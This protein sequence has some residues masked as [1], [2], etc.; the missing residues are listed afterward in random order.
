[1][2]DNPGHDEEKC[3]LLKYMIDSEEEPSKKKT[4]KEERYKG[5]R[6]R[7]MAEAKVQPPYCQICRIWGD[8][9]T[10]ECPTQKDKDLSEKKDKA[11]RKKEQYCPHCK[12]WG[13][14][15]EPFCKFCQNHTHSLEDCHIRKEKLAKVVCTYCRARGQHDTTECPYKEKVEK[16]LKELQEEQER[17]LEQERLEQEIENRVNK[18]REIDKQI[19]DKIAGIKKE[20]GKDPSENENVWSKKSGEN[21]DRGRKDEPPKRQEVGKDREDYQPPEEKRGQPMEGA[22][23]GGDDP[24]PGDDG[25]ESDEESTDESESEEDEEEE[26]TDSENEEREMRGEEGIID[27]SA[28]PEEE[29]VESFAS[30]M[31]SMWDFLGNKISRKQFETWAKWH[32]QQLKDKRL[33]DLQGPYLARGRRGHR[34]HKG[35]D[36]LQG[37][38]GPQGPQGPPGQTNIQEGIPPGGSKQVDPNITIDMSPLDQ[39][40]RDLGD[41]MKEVWSAQ[42][43]MNKIMKKQLEVS[44]EAQDTQTKVMQEL[45]DSNNQ[46][47]FD[48]MFANI[49][50]Y[51]GENP[52]EFDDWAERLETACMIS[53]RD[54]R[55]AAITL[56]SGAAT[57][58]IKSMNKTE[59]WSVIKAELRRCFSENKTKIHSAILF[60][61]FRSQGN[62]EN[63]RSYIYVYTKAHR[64]ATGVT[65]KKEFDIGRKIDFLTKLRNMTI[66]SKIGQSEDFRKYDKYSLD[67]CFQ[68]ALQLESKFQA[69]E[70]MNMTRENRILEQKILQQKKDDRVGIFGL[71]DGTPPAVDNAMRG[72]CY[73]CGARGHLSYECD[74]DKTDGSDDERVVGKIDHTVQARTYITHKVLNDFI[75]KATKAEINKKIYQSRLKQAQGQQQ[76]QQLQQPQPFKPKPYKPKP[77]QPNVPQVPVVQQPPLQPTAPPM[78]QVPP[79][80]MTIP[81]TTT[82]PMVQPIQKPRGRPRAKP[83]QGGTGQT[84]VKVVAPPATVQQPIV[85]TPTSIPVP[86]HNVQPKI[87][88]DKVQELEQEVDTDSVQMNYDTDEVANLDSE[89]EEEEAEE[90]ELS[91]EEIEEQQ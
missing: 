79:V 9:S 24:D 1:M 74:M 49:K 59:P 44:R 33:L 69:N 54:I 47:N 42:H 45:R 57:K 88:I 89:P 16:R 6:K 19:K 55:E 83:K 37:P 71:Q 28:S 5:K 25:D 40:F 41:S 22:G 14:A 17:Q 87:V 18:L 56:S 23:G 20:T 2:C 38:P 13:H 68:K 63:L 90:I 46:R 75:Q 32:L 58:V 67:D 26:S 48:Y 27:E 60:K 30:S 34:G 10:I 36:G 82:T 65:A 8:H 11:D 4:K 15:P 66:A 80:T 50:V 62:N 51:N 29:A 91:P 77:F 39:T 3:P 81:V 35:K 72:P 61:N 70:M 21:R 78:P 53:G 52:E 64:E 31:I 85:I 84:A 86:P 76:Q 43:H 7:G 12:Q 73:R